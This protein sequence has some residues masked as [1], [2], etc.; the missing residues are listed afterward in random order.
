MLYPSEGM[1]CKVVSDEATLN[2]TCAFL[3][4]PSHWTWNCKQSRKLRLLFYICNEKSIQNEVLH[5]LWAA[6]LL[7]QALAD[8]LLSIWNRM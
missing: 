7:L 6:V 8:I 4:V 5:D 2:F 1:A 3:R